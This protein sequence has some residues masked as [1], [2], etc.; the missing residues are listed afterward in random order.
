MYHGKLY[1]KNNIFEIRYDI[2]A[3][4]SK[5]HLLILSACFANLQV[6]GSFKHKQIFMPQ[7]EGK[8]PLPKNKISAS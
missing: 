7:T 5:F 3:K 2:K 6:H 8:G 4:N 1:R